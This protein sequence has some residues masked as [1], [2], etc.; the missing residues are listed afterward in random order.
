MEEYNW[1]ALSYSAKGTIQLFAA[2]K[3]HVMPSR[4]KCFMK[5]IKHLKS[6]LSKFAA[7]PRECECFTRWQTEQT[8]NHK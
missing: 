2:A 1:A 6:S 4:V 8:V 7:A 3:C 5:Q